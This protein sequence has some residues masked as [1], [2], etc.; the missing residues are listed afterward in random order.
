MQYNEFVLVLRASNAEIKDT[1][2]E[3][4]IGERKT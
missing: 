3:S 2:K 1:V 4:V